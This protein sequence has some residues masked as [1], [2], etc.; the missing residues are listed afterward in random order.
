M[1]CPL[2]SDSL[3]REDVLEMVQGNLSTAQD[4]KD[5]LE[6]RQRKDKKARLAHAAKKK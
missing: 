4:L 3:L 5:L 1:P 2:M 6:E